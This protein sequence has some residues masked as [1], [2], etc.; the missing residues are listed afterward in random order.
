MGRLRHA[1]LCLLLFLGFSA[2]KAQDA[3][4]FIL[5]AHRAGI[6]EL[7]DPETLATAARIHFD[8]A[9][10]SSGLNG[11]SAS[12]DGSTLYVEGA[13]PPNP[14]CCGLYAVD[15]ATMKTVAT[16][17]EEKFSRK[18]SPLIFSDGLVYPAATLMPG[19]PTRDF[20]IASRN[21]RLL[22]SPDGRWLFGV[23]SFRGPALETFDLNHGAAFRELTPAGRDPSGTNWANG[24]WSGDHFYFYAADGT[25]S[26]RLWTVSPG[27]EQLGVG[28]EVAAFGDV[29]GCRQGAPVATALTAAAGSLFIYEPFG[30]KSDRSLD[31]P[32]APGGAWIVD[33][34]TGQLT[35]QIAPGFHFN[36][37]IAARGGHDIYGLDPGN[38]S[39]TGPVRLVR[40]DARNGTI[41][42]SV[43][44]DPGVCTIATAA[45]RSAPAGDVH[46]NVGIE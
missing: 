5:A 42:K 27:T 35:G 1:A 28:V 3:K 4:P 19:G 39:W 20:T 12:A 9:P 6:V 11:V 33:S 26:G 22:L 2:T 32:N 18:N 13:V 45:L 21:A 41:L 16:T 40:M 25:N 34:A 30:N 23:R 43:T 37:L 7:I 46:V 24:A 38:V 44:L 31:C 29:P 36:R 10:R 17:I 15:M 14:S 8:L